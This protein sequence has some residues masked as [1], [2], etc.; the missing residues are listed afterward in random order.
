MPCLDSNM[1]LCHDDTCLIRLIHTNPHFA[2][3]SSYTCLAYLYI[4]N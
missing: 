4:E 1:N 3:V 2:C